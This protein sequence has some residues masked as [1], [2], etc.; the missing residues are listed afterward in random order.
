M[1]HI[2]NL[3]RCVVSI[4]TSPRIIC[5]TL[6]RNKAF[7]S[8]NDSSLNRKPHNVLC[9]YVYIS[10]LWWGQPCRSKNIKLAPPAKALPGRKRRP[11][12]R[13]HSVTGAGAPA[14]CVQPHPGLHFAP[15]MPP[16][17]IFFPEGNSVFFCLFIRGRNAWGQSAW[18]SSLRALRLRAVRLPEE[19]PA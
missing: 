12:G 19:A 1:L 13:G 10:L 4:F 18:G 11:A 7:F 17:G 16:L 14:H 5:P 2:A 6:T 8:I 15:T 3:L 9:Q